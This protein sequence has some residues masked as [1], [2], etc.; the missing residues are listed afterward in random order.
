ME[1]SSRFRCG[2]PARSAPVDGRGRL[3]PTFVEWMMGFPAGWT[4]G[5]KRNQA[6]KC[7]GNAVVSQQARVVWD[8]L[9]AETQQGVR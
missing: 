6:L 5:L 1:L 7:L 9:W 2:S 8:L 3:S 4:D